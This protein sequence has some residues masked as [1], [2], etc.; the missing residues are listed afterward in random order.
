M[1]KSVKA[2]EEDVRE[3]ED[4]HEALQVLNDLRLREGL[5]VQTKAEKAAEFKRMRDLMMSNWGTKDE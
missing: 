2:V 5:K 4:D 3:N 1:R